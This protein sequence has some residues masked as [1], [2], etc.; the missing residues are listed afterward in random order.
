MRSFALAV[1]V[2]GLVP[3]ARSAEAKVK[4]KTAAQAVGAVLRFSAPKG[5]TASDYSNSEGADPVVRFESLSDA[6]I[7]RVYGAPGSAYKTPAEFMAGPAATSQGV[8]PSEDGGV[9]IA[10]KKLPLYRRRYPINVPNP[11]GPP[12]PLMLGSELFAVLP[13]GGGRFAVLSYQRAS[14]APDLEGKG[15]KAW[16][17]FL[18]TVRPAA[19][20]KPVKK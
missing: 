8:A 18:K 3:A 13:L 16:R 17:E 1:L 14:P 9:E 6:V 12:A 10:G 19:K 4:T 15:E 7:V 5:W 11:H 2:A 20:A